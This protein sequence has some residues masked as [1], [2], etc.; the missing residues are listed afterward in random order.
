MATERTWTEQDP[1]GG[2][3]VGSLILHGA[4]AAALVAAGFILHHGDTWG[5]ASAQAGAIQA[6][7]VSSLPLPS[8]QRFDENQV[9]ASDSPSPAPRTEKAT[10]APP[11][12]D[13]IPI[14]IKP[15]KT[16]PKVAEKETPPPPK[17]QQPVKQNPKVA[18]TGETSGIRIAQSTV[19][20][21]NGTASVTVQDSTFGARYAYYVNVVNRTVAQNWFTQ[22]ADPVASNGRSVTIIFDILRDGT[23]TNVRIG[24]RSGSRSLDASAQH[25]LQRVDG[26]GP[27]PA[28]DHITVEYTFNYQPH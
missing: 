10:V 7:M 19:Q 14:P 12:A 26:F 2:T 13:E 24:Q 6:T 18:Q 11:K 16:P 4:V 3:F 17:F 8:T 27:L 9:L 5:G 28:G 1:I 25:A 21:K 22:E 23:P 15:T 20:V